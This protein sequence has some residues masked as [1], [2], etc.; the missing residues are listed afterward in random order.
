MCLG[1]IGLSQDTRP[2]LYD[3]THTTLEIKKVDFTAETLE[4]VAQL[5]FESKINDLKEVQ[6]DLAVSQFDSATVNGKTL[7]TIKEK[8]FLLT[9]PIGRNNNER[10]TIHQTNIN[11]IV[12]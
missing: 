9:Q 10:S 12:T 3:L 6:F 1:F 4:G 2:D 8:Y 7:K 11:R 5:K